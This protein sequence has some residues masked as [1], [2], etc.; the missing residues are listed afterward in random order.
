MWSIKVAPSVSMEPLN[1]EAWSHR[2]KLVVSLHC[3]L[4]SCSAVYCNRSCLWVCDSG[5]AGGV[6]TLL[7][8]ARAQCLRLY[9]RLFHCC[10]CSC[11]PLLT[12]QTHS[13]MTGCS[14]LIQLGLYSDTANPHPL[15]VNGHFFYQANNTEQV[16]ELD[17]L[18][19]LAG[20]RTR[21]LTQVLSSF[22]S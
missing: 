17:P 8:P 5:R 18:H 10:S 15:T 14:F 19:F 9:E 22:I 21:Q 16:P 2:G 11:K 7:Q 13:L 3:A 1:A 20:C 4:A 6:W 12:T